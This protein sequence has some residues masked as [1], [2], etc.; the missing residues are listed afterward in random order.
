M[1]NYFR[2]RQDRIN[3][4]MNQL[5]ASH[6]Q[7][8]ETHTFMNQLSASHIQEIETHTFMPLTDTSDFG[9]YNFMLDPDYG[10]FTTDV[11]PD[12]Q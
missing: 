7:E 11:Q 8:I 3:R 1:G 9:F 5:S 12:Y 2:R 4:K 10:S 6:I